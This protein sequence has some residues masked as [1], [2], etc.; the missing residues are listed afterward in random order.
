[1][2]DVRGSA[3]RHILSSWIESAQLTMDAS[4]QSQAQRHTKACTWS[5]H[6]YSAGVASSR[7]SMAVVATVALSMAAGTEVAAT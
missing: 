6:L 7:L 3:Q 1:M 5:R 4:A 2:R